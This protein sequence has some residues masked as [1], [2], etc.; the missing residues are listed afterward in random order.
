MADALRVAG[1][2]FAMR[3]RPGVPNVL[4][5]VTYSAQRPENQ[6][7]Q[8]IEEQSMRNRENGIYQVSGAGVGGAR[9]WGGGMS[10]VNFK[11]WQLSLRGDIKIHH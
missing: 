2:H 7:I 10:H 5:L 4:L 1:Q 11:K 9:D 6:A 8:L 3:G